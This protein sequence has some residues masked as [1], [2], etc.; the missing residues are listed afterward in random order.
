MTD[1]K[2]A[3][4]HNE[5][6]KANGYKCGDCPWLHR[7]RSYGKSWYKCPYYGE[8]N[9][10]ATDWSKSWTACGLHDK[11]INGITPLVKRIEAKRAE[12]EPIDGQISMFEEDV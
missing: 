11:C 4:M 9:S 10:Q 5:Y 6:G 8:S 12:N 1:Q 2:I 7:V 3:A